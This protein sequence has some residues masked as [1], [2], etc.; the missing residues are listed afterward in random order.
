MIEARD[1]RPEKLVRFG[2][3][4]TTSNAFLLQQVVPSN[5]NQRRIA[6]PLP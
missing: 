4:A 6:M 1:L 2:E 3:K 5:C